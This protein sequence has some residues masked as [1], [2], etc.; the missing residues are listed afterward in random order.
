MT[1]LLYMNTTHNEVNTSI[2]D[3]EKEIVDCLAKG[4]SEKEIGEKLYISPKTVNNHLT[5]I[6]AKLGV[7]KNIEIIAYYLATLKGKKF[8][9]KLLKEYGIAIFVLLLNVCRLNELP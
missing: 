9:L 2:S 4:M 3:R 7:N 8:D 6:R 5:N 1:N